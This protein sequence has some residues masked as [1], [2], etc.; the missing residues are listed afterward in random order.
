MYAGFMPE[1]LNNVTLADATPTD[2]DQVDPAADEVTGGQFFHLQSVERSGIEVPVKTF[3]GLLLGKPG[4]VHTS[5]DSPFTASVGLGAQQPVQKSQVRKT[6][7]VGVRQHFI[8]H[9]WLDRNSQCCEMAEA[10]VMQLV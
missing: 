5:R 4:I 7:L 1:R 2:H 8:Q 10:A 6:L 3:E 9:R